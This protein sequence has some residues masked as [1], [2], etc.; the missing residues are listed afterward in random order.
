ML[1]TSKKSVH[2]IFIQSL[3]MT[4]MAERKISEP[5]P[6]QIQRVNYTDY[7]IP[8]AMGVRVQTRNKRQSLQCTMNDGRRQEYHA[9]K[10]TQCS[11]CFPTLKCHINIFQWDKGQPLLLQR[12]S[13]RFKRGK[14]TVA[15]ERSYGSTNGICHSALPVKQRH[16]P[17]PHKKV[18][19][20][21]RQISF[22]VNFYV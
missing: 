2:K 6:S 19:C 1:N 10:Q 12:Y 7:T 20:P 11:L 16:P 22:I 15:K 8:A 9:S 13:G 3:D 4:K 17:P 21:I 14:R 18:T 5:A